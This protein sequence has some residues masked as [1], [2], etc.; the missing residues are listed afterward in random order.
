L[1]ERAEAAPQAG[2][3]GL[4]VRRKWAA[5]V[6]GRLA[7]HGLGARA[8][9]FAEDAKFALPRLS[10]DGA[11]KRAYLL[12]PDPWWKKK[13]T[14][15][16][17]M[18]DAFL[19]QIARLLEKGGELFVETDVEERAEQYALQIADCPLFTAFGDV[20]GSPV[21]VDNPYGARSPREHRAIA[22][23]LPIHRLRYKRV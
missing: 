1:F 15:R 2:L 19:E 16:L 18:G 14:K 6:D 20:T 21:V 5:I 22:D 8:R 12:F 7:K 23:G 4:E 17:V 3:V 13:H 9:V 10:P 11:F